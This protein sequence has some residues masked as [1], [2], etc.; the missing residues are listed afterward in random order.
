MSHLSVQTKLD[1]F[2]KQVQLLS[3]LLM[4]KCIVFLWF[5]NKCSTVILFI[6]FHQHCIYH[7]IFHLFVF[8]LSV[9]N[10]DDPP[11]LGYQPL[12]GTCY[13]CI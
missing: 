7:Y 12:R 1:S 4:N 13:L 6:Y 2:F 10:P 8:S 5:L 9:T 11:P 3:L